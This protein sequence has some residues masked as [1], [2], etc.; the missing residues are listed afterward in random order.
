VSL[1]LRPAVH[2]T[3]G[4]AEVESIEGLSPAISVDQKTISFNPRSTVGTITEI[5]DLLRLLYARLGTI[6]CPD[7][8]VPVRA[9]S[10][11][12]ILD[13]L[14]SRFSGLKS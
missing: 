9:S 14:N 7:C 5:Y 2:R 3:T 8:Q 13:R 1:D 11:E 4:K 6:Y 12:Q 10:R